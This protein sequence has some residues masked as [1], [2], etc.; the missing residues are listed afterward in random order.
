MN[1]KQQSPWLAD[2]PPVQTGSWLEAIISTASA[3]F[4]AMFACA[5]SVTKGL[6]YIIV[7]HSDTGLK[8]AEKYQIEIDAQAKIKRAKNYYYYYSPHA[9]KDIER[10]L[11]HYKS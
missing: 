11:E 4:R 6:I 2:S 9:K 8:A 1:R 3:V 5:S 7:N 10:K